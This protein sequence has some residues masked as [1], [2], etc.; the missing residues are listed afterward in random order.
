MPTNEP[1]G[2][3]T[4]RVTPPTPRGTDPDSARDRAPRPGDKPIAFFRDDDAGEL[5]PE[6]KRVAELMLAEGVPCNYAV[7]PAYLSRRTADWLIGLRREN[8]G[9]IEIN[10]HG[11]LHEQV[12]RG[13][14]CYSEFGGGRPFEDQRRAIAEGRELLIRLF[15]EHLGAEVF[16]P[17]SN[18]FDESTLRAMVE[19]GFTI[20]SGLVKT[21][22]Y[23]R[24][25]YDVG[26]ALSKTHLLGTPIS[27]HERITPG[28]GLLELSTAIDIDGQ[29]RLLGGVHLKDAERLWSELERARRVQRYVGTMIHHAAYRSQSKLDTLREFLRAIR[30]EGIEVRTIEAIALELRARAA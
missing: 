21:V 11:F 9:M 28:F 4:L 30:R 26:Y 1:R 2:D 18:R 20:L 23:R 13:R 15:G 24:V 16:T 29:P 27:Y 7:V 19:L 12:I 5:T 14:H 3:P 17:P 22:R 10:Q 6:L 8:P 25:V